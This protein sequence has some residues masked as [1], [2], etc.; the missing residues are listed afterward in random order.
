VN[1]EQRREISTLEWQTSML[2][3]I[4]NVPYQAL[5]HAHIIAESHAQ[6]SLLTKELI[7][8]R[9]TSNELEASVFWFTAAAEEQRK[10]GYSE[11]TCEHRGRQPLPPLSAC[12]MHVQHS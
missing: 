3:N 9:P 4:I 1:G 7:C 5:F 11:Q 6:A 2:T 8:H 10:S 12:M